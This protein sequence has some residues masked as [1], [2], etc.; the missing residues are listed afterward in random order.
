M[1][2]RMEEIEGHKEAP[3]QLNFPL[4]GT[5]HQSTQRTAQ[6][7]TAQHKKPPPLSHSHTG[8]LGGMAAQ[9]HVKGN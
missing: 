2:R 8:I 1:A 3:E 7:S 4:A 6:H 9:W 5:D